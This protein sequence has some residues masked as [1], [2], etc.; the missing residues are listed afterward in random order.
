MLD[1]ARFIVLC[2]ALAG[3]LAGAAETL[4][5]D[6]PTYAKVYS[7][8]VGLNPAATL[9]DLA[10]LARKTGSV[11]LLNVTSERRSMRTGQ[12]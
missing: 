8:R 12:A 5:K 2:F 1:S 9:A 3:L 6:E 10:A 7:A 4:G 11:E